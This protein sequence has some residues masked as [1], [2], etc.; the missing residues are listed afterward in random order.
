MSFTRALE[1][2]EALDLKE[3]QA[4]VHNNLG[5]LHRTAGRVKEATASFTRALKL[6]DTL[7]LPEREAGVH[8]NLG[9]LHREAGRGRESLASYLR[10]LELYKTL[11]LPER[12]AEIYNAVGD[13]LRD[14]VQWSDAAASYVQ[15]LGLYEGLGLVEGQANSHERLGML[16]LARSDFS[17]SLKSFDWAVGLYEAQGLVQDAAWAAVSRARV[18]RGLSGEEVTVGECLALVVPAA[19]FLDSVRFQFRDA[20]ERVAW[21]VKAGAAS[22]LALELAAASEDP[23]LVADLVETHINSVVHNSRDRNN[24]GLETGAGTGDAGAL[25]MSARAAGI[26][27]IEAAG[28]GDKDPFTAAAGP[29][30]PEAGGSFGN[31]FVAAGT[32]RLLSHAGLPGSPPPF[33]LIPSRAGDRMALGSWHERSRYPAVD[34]P[35]TPVRTW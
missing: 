10:A 5:T 22:A 4:L 29:D 7:D 6:Y 35:S 32:I 11:N 1:L 30:N 16:A 25:L 19:L 24:A 14:A 23:G 18:L 9:L 28:T 13:L 34:R 8:I 27:L 17:A 15:A 3:M 26:E 21:S 31:G 12:Q 2:F 33:L 20:S